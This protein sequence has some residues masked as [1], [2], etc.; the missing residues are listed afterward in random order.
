MA[1]HSKSEKRN[2]LEG[3]RKKKKP[4]T[5]GEEKGGAHRKSG[6]TAYSRE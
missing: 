3:A 1:L 6:K 4:R 5:Q 2:K